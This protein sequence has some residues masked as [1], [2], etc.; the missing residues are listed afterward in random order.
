MYFASLH[1]QIFLP[2]ITNHATTGKYFLVMEI[3]V[4]VRSARVRK[5]G[6]LPRILS[7]NNILETDVGVVPVSIPRQ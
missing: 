1:H 6:V 5:S 7:T 4:C 2:K 3:H